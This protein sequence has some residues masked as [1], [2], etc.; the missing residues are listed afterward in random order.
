MTDACNWNAPGVDPYRGPTAASVAAAVQRYKLPPEA[1]AELVRKAR[2]LQ[3]DAVVTITRDGIYSADGTASDLRDMHH[4]KPGRVCAGPVVRSR[5]RDDHAET[6][7]VYCAG[8]ECIAVPTVCG[9]VARITWA[10]TAPPPEPAFRAWRPAPPLPGTRHPAPQPVPEP[11]TLALV[12]A[13]LGV[14]AATRRPP[15]GP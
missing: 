8:R 6:A 13:A 4:G 10:P 1:Q 5:W 2:M 12:A 3:P 9:N 14:L 15:P 7:L 11:S